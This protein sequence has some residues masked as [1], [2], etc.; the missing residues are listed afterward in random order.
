MKKLTNYQLNKVSKSLDCY[1]ELATSKDFTEGVLWY[2]QAHFICRDLAK[3]YNTTTYIVAGIISSLS[4]RN[5]WPQNI[6]DAEIVLSAIHAGLEPKDV[7]VC[8][9]HRNKD[10]AFSIAKGESIITDQSMKTFSFINNIA[11][12][13][14]FYIT[15]DVWHL[16]ACFGKDIRTTPGKIAYEQLRKLT[17]SKAKKLN[18]QGFEYQAVLWN[19]V[20]N[21][22]KK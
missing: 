17:I 21:N 10:K 6:K 4:P 5:K 20:K 12:L 2:E 1:L 7:K 3:K 14:N 16:R 9:F 13:N 19:S 22:F 11:N 15:I 8:T 18:L